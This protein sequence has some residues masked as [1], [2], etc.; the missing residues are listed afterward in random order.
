M[1]KV[2]S[3]LFFLIAI[4]GDI[5]FSQYSISG[6]VTDSSAGNPLQNVKAELYGMNRSAFSDEEGKFSFSMEKW[7]Y[8][9]TVSG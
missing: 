7:G 5:L 9:V 3:L 4:S 1:P 8:T 2:I 6:Y